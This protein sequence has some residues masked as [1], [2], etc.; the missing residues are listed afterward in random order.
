MIKKL[1]YLKYYGK[2]LL[3]NWIENKDSYAQHGEDKLVE[4]LLP[5]GVNSFIDI[6]AND[7]VLFSNTYKFAK[8]GATGLC[9]E[10]SPRSYTKLKL[11]HLFHSKI[12]CINY[13]ISNRDGK[14][15]FIED[16]YEETLSR[17][18]NSNEEGSKEIQ[19]CTFNTI[20]NKY[21]NFK[22]IDLLSVDVEGHE[23]E[24]F[25]SLLKNSLKIKLI[26]IE[27]D[28]S[29]FEK[30]TNIPFLSDY[31]IIHTNG[32]NTFLLNNRLINNSHF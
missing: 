10:P 13:A 6:G 32:I 30:L 22:D 16:G 21:P 9:I 5:N 27:S 7:G 12:T 2:V 8:Y 28:K 24:V 23:Y 18:S 31:H 20:L 15:Y 17:V 19:C 11:N 25:R 4:Q 29:K 14:I 1:R 3:N 26:I